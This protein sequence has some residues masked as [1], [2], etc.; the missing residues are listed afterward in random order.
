M[1]SPVGVMVRPWRHPEHGT[2]RRPPHTRPGSPR[3]SCRSPEKHQP[4]RVGNLTQPQMSAVVSVDGN[5]QILTGHEQPPV[6]VE[7]RNIPVVP[8]GHQPRTR[9]AVPLDPQQAMDTLIHRA[10][11]IGGIGQ[12]VCPF[13]GAGQPTPSQLYPRRISKGHGLYAEPVA[14]QGRFPGFQSRRVPGCKATD[15]CACLRR[16]A[17][18]D[19]CAL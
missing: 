13:P 16:G 9:L 6:F 10:R 17:A 1:A 12:P 19:E 8:I 11:G 18:R 7:R 4:Q 5:H 14:C 3:Q 2:C 15:P